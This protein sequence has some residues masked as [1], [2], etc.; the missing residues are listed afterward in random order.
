MLPVFHVSDGHFQ[1]TKNSPIHQ[2]ADRKVLKQ[3]TVVWEKGDKLTT[4]YEC[5]IELFHHMFDHSPEGMEIGQQ[6][7]VVKQE[8]RYKVCTGVFHTLSWKQME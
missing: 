7:H 2:P 1:P 3:A 5:F 6:L 8:R 4:L